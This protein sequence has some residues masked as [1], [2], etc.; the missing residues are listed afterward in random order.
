MDGVIA[1]GVPVLR[2]KT[3]GCGLPIMYGCTNFCSIASCPT[4]AAGSAAGKKG[5]IDEARE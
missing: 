3:Q 4:F 2:D 5:I 1:E